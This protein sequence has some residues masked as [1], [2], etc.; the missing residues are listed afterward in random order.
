MGESLTK[1]LSGQVDKALDKD[2]HKAI[3]SRVLEF[4]RKSGTRTGLD[5]FINTMQ[6]KGFRNSADAPLG[7]LAKKVVEL[8]GNNRLVLDIVLDIWVESL[9]EMT[10]A[11][12]EYLDDHIASFQGLKDSM[13]D[14]AEAVDNL[15]TAGVEHISDKTGYPSGGIRVMLA[16]LAREMLEDEERGGLV[17]DGE[18]DNEISGVDYSFWSAML[19]EIGTLPPEAGEWDLVERFLAEVVLL[20]DKKAEERDI[21][22]RCDEALAQLVLECREGLAFFG[23]EE[24]KSWR[25]KCV[26]ADEAA[27]L[28][29][30]LDAMRKTLLRHSEL[31]QATA[32]NVTEMRE[33]RTELTG[34]EQRAE[35]IFGRL[36]AVP[37]FSHGDQGPVD[38]PVP[39]PLTAPDEKTDTA[40]TVAGIE[41][42]DCDLPRDGLVSGRTFPEETGP[43][44]EASV[45]VQGE[46]PALEPAGDDGPG[47]D[48]LEPPVVPRKEGAGWE[49]L[50]WELVAEDDLAGAY[51]LNESLKADNQSPVLPG[52]LVQAVLGARWLIMDH[53][54]FAGGLLRI[55]R[56]Y[57]PGDTDLEEVLGL[58]A[59]L[60]SAVIAP[61]SGMLAWLKTPGCFPV[62]ND[63][64]LAVKE[65]ANLG[66]PLRGMDLLG[67]ADTRQIEGYIK[68]SADDA[69]HWLEQA[70]RR[71]TK[72]GRATNV[73]TE[74]VGGQGELRAF[75][76]PVADDS[77]E[78]CTVIRQQAEQWLDRDFVERRVTDIDRAITG[79]RLSPI[80]GGALDQIVRFARDAS[81]AALRWCELVE[82]D[83]E[84]RTRGRDWFAGRVLALQAG[85]QTVMDD[86]RLKIGE[87]GRD[88]DYGLAAA[89]S[90]LAR[91]LDQ[92]CEDLGLAKEMAAESGAWNWLAENV[93]DMDAAMARRLALLPEIDLDDFGNP[94]AE[95]RDRIGPA[96]TAH[97]KNR[98]TSRE[99]FERWL[100]KKD[101]RFI[102]VVL[103][104]V[105]DEDERTRLARQYEEELGGSRAALEDDIH[106]TMDIIEQAVVDG[107]L[108]NEERADE[109]SRLE[110]IDPKE[111]F[112]YR[113]QY[114]RLDAIRLSVATARQ[115]RMEELRGEWGHLQRRLMEHPG[116]DGIKSGIAATVEDALARGD[117]RVVEE[118]IAKLTEL[119]DSG[120]TMHDNPFDLPPERGDVQSQFAEG[121]ARLTE[122]LEK[123]GLQ[124]L[125]EAV[126]NGQS[127]GGLNFANRP[128]GLR[129]EDLTA[130]EAWRRLK[131]GTAAVGG[132]PLHI[133]AVLR[134]LGFNIDH[135]AGTAVTVKKKG[136]HWLHLGTEMSAGGRSPVAQ[137]GSQQQNLY[138]VF[139]VWERPSIDSLAGWVRDLRLDN[140]NILVVY[141]GRMS[142]R[143]RK[144]MRQ[145][146]SDRGLTLIV[147]DEV[148][149]AFLAG[150]RLERLPAFFRCALPFSALNPYTPFRAG[151]VPPE[152]FF[153]R[154]TMARELQRAE[155][156]CLVYGGR[157]LG[158]S[159]LLRHVQREFHA[160]ERDQYAHVE[161]IKFVGS[162]TSHNRPDV[163]WLK[164][165]DIFKSF[166]L[167]SAVTTERPEQIAKLIENTLQKMP[168]VRVLI[169]F[170]EADSFLDADAENDFK[171]VDG[172]RVLMTN[173]QRRLKVVLAGLHSVQRFQ[174]MANQPLAHFGTPLCV[175]PLEA[176]ASQRLIREP[177]GALGFR[178]SD[179]SVV[180]S[181]L[182]YTN[183]HPGL[184]QL[185]CQE[186]LNRTNARPCGDPPYPI[187]RGDVE[188]IYRNAEVRKRI[189]ERFD[190]TLALD[191]RYQAI[192][193]AMI[194]D[195][196]DMRDG[197]A[198]SYGSGDILG[199]ARKWW[200]RGFE[201][202]ETDQLRGLLDEMHGLGVLVHDTRGHYRLR[203]PNL[204]RLMEDVESRLLDLSYREP[205]IKGFDSDSY[206]APLGD[207]VKYSPLTYTQEGNLNQRRFGVGIVF[208]SEALGLSGLGAAFR[209][210]IPAGLPPDV[211]TDVRAMPADLTEGG[212]LEEWLEKYLSDH[213]GQERLVLYGPVGG[214]SSPGF[215]LIR[216]ALRF[217]RRYRKRQKQWLRVLFVFG[218]YGA[219]SWLSL[220]EGERMAL[221][222]QADAVTRLRRWN[223]RAILQRLA[224]Q[225]KIYSE[226]VRR[227]IFHV[228]GGWPYLLDDLFDRCGSHDDPRP[229]V[230]QME[231]ELGDPGTPLFNGFWRSLGFE[232]SE[233]IQRILGFIMQ[234]DGIPRELAEP[235][236]LAELMHG[237]T[238]LPLPEGEAGIL[239]A[240]YMGLT[241]LRDGALRLEPAV[242]RM[243]KL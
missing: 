182:S 44:G 190:W 111:T 75:L 201:G 195:Q 174:S 217:T 56:N 203:S 67:A 88:K 45:A 157:Q 7:I 196:V 79:R 36:K 78:R 124:A 73:L 185:F 179:N 113:A 130:I 8:T 191:P 242:E 218:P 3:V 231:T 137:F 164:I 101:Y 150:E 227:D 121:S 19:D 12:E 42:P 27:A 97:R 62:V 178:F 60:R 14:K 51:W 96:L 49:D 216:S 93:E 136:E 141:L 122:A 221:E 154:R 24:A 213:A 31:R 225:D 98:V 152:M 240:N 35:E 102:H 176:D 200:P 59:S 30:Q 63:L 149:F 16:F 199:L 235:R 90:C 112:N 187:T 46:L 4:R 208:G 214:G 205:E 169:L 1:I 165:R 129:E 72:L 163:V 77:R 39:E 76:Q 95:T 170:D 53:S 100:E 228:T 159:A 22:L 140:R 186:I 233:S 134:F 234:E 69:G 105:G 153:G 155:G 222:N 204:V 52:W 89:L 107:I 108:S 168:G 9:P 166:G 238:G 123:Q 85:V 99:I 109:L 87:M 239:Y 74:L 17:I 241:E 38:R 146:T 65:F 142:L 54:N 184:I 5:F 207:S 116:E 32:S 2:L 232:P 70:P 91:S 202:T 126:R 18:K 171:V 119:L 71:H 183:Y 198:R 118:C 15:I 135:S 188:A 237:E 145:V 220:P 133:M 115:R 156:S 210:F 11:V 104:S 144:V 117:T 125:G 92:L 173:V 48:G 131:Q 82:R 110:N 10:G 160:P 13:G 148:L 68:T 20:A 167:L 41:K 181:I 57:Q 138:D 103:A 189:C 197:F 106:T 215:D 212:H 34:L 219:W 229:W 114:A 21:R 226:E 211:K 192:A 83:V 58:A 25:I 43:A 193:W 236:Q 209:Q 194:L 6:I 23:M 120:E 94:S 37:G 84:R 143:H 175:G 161:D 177:L 243:L 33:L 147:L 172:L 230:R 180:L 223:L 81:D 158:K 61:A 206:H 151:D 127:W 224:Q 47:G 86:V 80:T 132:N 139:C 28:T 29:D 40:A 162:A 128:H 66:R 64:V 50:F 55:A 26:P